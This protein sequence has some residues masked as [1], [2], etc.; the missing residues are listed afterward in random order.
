MSGLSPSDWTTILQRG[1]PV[2]LLGKLAVRARDAG[3]WDALPPA[4]QRQLASMARLS[5]YNHTHLKAEAFYIARGLRSLDIPLV[6][7]KGGGY[8][9]AGLAVDRG[10]L[11]SDI[12]ILVPKASID[13]AEAALMQIGWQR[14]QMSAYDQEYYRRWMHELPPLRHRNRA[15]VVDIHHTI[16]PLTARIL[17]DAGALIANARPPETGGETGGETGAL[18]ALVLSPEDMLVHVAVHAFYD[19]DLNARLRDVLD[20]HEMVLEF[21]DVSGFWDRLTDRAALHQAGRPL[22]Y[23]LY[24][25]HHMLDTPLPDGFL[26][27]LDPP[28]TMARKLMTW[29][30]PRAVL[31][32][33]PDWEARPPAATRLA[34]FMLFI[35]SHWLRMPPLLLARHLSI[36]ALRGV[37]VRL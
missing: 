31:P 22:Y 4:V 13:D 5:E 37:K 35:R 16:L 24:F 30:V 21:A 34:R 17:P 8:A 28:G 14:L 19:G 2:A 1:R 20:V 29:A 12:D 6:F 3:V 36:K 33:L 23:A 32:S 10:R 9:L 27:R 25:A 26:D 7:L 15:T 18:S 11:S